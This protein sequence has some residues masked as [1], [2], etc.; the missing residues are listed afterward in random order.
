MRPDSWASLLAR[1]GGEVDR[2]GGWSLDRLG[3]P[4]VAIFHSEWGYGVAIG[5]VELRAPTRA[6]ARALAERA[7]KLL[8]DG[9]RWPIAS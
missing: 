1:Y 2:Y 9:G 6:K 4:R 5:N 8:V 3:A 7:I